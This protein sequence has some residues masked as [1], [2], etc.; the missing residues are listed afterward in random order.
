MTSR[1]MVQ[2]DLILSWFAV[3]TGRRLGL[4]ALPVADE[5]HTRSRYPVICKHV[6]MLIR[7]VRR[8]RR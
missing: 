8:S 2:L 3:F 1:E 7:H 4:R 5:G 6:G